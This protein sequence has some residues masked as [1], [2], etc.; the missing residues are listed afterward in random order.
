MKTL[1]LSLIMFITL[2]SAP[3]ANEF[4][5]LVEAVYHEAR[6]EG[7]AGMLSVAG[8]ILTRV[9]NDNYPNTVCEVVHQ[10]KKWNGH[11]IKHK[12]QFS[13][14]CDGRSEK[15]KDM[16]SLTEVIKVVHMSLLG[17][18]VKQTV[19]STHYHA[20]HVTPNWASDPQ[21]KC[22]GQL[23]SHVFY[24]DTRS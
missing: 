2:I 17:I 1:L 16:N 23:G 20:S 11:I 6:S 9:Q 7:L 10:G 15:Y 13:Y 22:L 8:V 19:G 18:Q 21:F 14:Y 4:N 5:C 12:C 24:I 3:K